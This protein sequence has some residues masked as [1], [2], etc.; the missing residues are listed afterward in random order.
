MPGATPKGPTYARLAL[1]TTGGTGPTTCYAYVQTIT[2]C[3]TKE[4]STLRTVMPT[5]RAIVPGSGRCVF[6]RLTT[7]LRIQ[8]STTD[9]ASPV[10]TKSKSCNSGGPGVLM[11][12]GPMAAA[13]AQPGMVTP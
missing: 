13:C 4:P 12:L 6:T 7:S 1:L 2:S 3:L 9:H 5:G 10:S 8:S 11:I